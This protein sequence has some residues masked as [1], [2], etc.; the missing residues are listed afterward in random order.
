MA[1]KAVLAYSDV[2][3][4]GKYLVDVFP[5]REISIVCERYGRLTC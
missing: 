2:A 3:S 1:E 4:P 5:F